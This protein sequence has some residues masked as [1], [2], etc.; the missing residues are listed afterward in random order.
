MIIRTKKYK[1]P[2]RVYILLGMKNIIR[3]QWW[4]FLIAIGILSGTFFIKTIWFVIIA[5]VGLILYFLFWLIQFYGVTQLEQN[6]LIFERLGYEITSQQI[7]MQINTKQGMPIL[8][9][10][11]KR[12]SQGKDYFLLV[13]T[14]SHLIQLPYKI[15]NSKNE[16]KFV[17]TILKRRGLLK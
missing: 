9:E 15:F 8:W 13:I 17:E 3:E 11:V 7:M 12:A 1:L 10:Q 2:N 5:T 4:V 14:K 16:V 6:Q